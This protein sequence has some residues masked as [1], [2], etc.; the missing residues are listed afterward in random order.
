MLASLAN[1]FQQDGGGALHHCDYAL[2]IAGDPSSKRGTQE[3]RS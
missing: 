3:D 2:H 1:N